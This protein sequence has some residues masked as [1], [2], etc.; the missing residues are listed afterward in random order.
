MKCS[1]ARQIMMLAMQ[2]TPPEA[3]E[4]KRIEFHLSHCAAC[5]RWKVYTEVVEEGTEE[6]ENLPPVLSPRLQQVIA[7]ARAAEAEREQPHAR[8]IESAPERGF[9]WQL[10]SRR[11]VWGTALATTAIVLLTAGYLLL[12]NSP[13]SNGSLEP[14]QIA[15]RTYQ[16]VQ[17]NSKATLD[18]G[19]LTKQ[20][21][22]ALQQDP[23]M[24]PLVHEPAFLSE[25]MLS[26]LRET[27]ES[28]NWQSVKR[29]LEE[30]EIVMPPEPPDFLIVADE[31]RGL[32]SQDAQETEFWVVQPT[33][34]ILLFILEETP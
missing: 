2:G 14:L 18:P 5:Q 32:I 7:E 9:A 33:S 24:S 30:Q 31:L 28:P 4:Q 21:L 22:P 6:P 29:A 27:L 11:L 23:T 19:S 12:T 3:S 25:E 17:L 1:D 15:G 20:A 10:L 13:I 34:E 8:P 16:V 26:V